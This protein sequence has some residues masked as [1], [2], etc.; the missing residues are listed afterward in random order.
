MLKRAWESIRHNVD[1]VGI[2]TCSCWRCRFTGFK[3]RLRRVFQ[4]GMP[5][6]VLLLFAS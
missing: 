5:A 4:K 2:D 6:Q 3:Q 1:Q